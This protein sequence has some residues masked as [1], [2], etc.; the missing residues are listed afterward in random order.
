MNFG[1]GEYVGN[2]NDDEDN[3]DNQDENVRYPN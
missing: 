3:Q 1:W 2:K